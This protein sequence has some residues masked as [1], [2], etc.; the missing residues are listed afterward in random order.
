VVWFNVDDGFSTS[1]K[2][3]G[4][5][6]GERMAAI[7]LWTI[8]GSW[9]SKHMTNGQIGSFM[10]DEWGA[11]PVSVGALITS[12]LWETTDEGF[13]FHDWTSWQR[14]RQQIEADREKERVRKK[15]WR[16]NKAG[17]SSFPVPDLSHG[18]DGGTPASVPRVS[19]Y[20][21]QALPSPTKPTLLSTKDSSS[22]LRPDVERLCILLRDLVIANGSK[23]PIIGPGW[24]TAARLMLVADGRDPEA[25]E[26]LM[27]WCQADPFWKANVLSMPKFRKG[28]DQIR[29]QAERQR[30]DRQQHAGKESKAD[31]AR[32]V[33][34]QGQRLQAEID[35]K[36]IAS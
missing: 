25:A 33:I 3:L 7:G 32:G 17:Q 1:P 4:I 8:A 35:R 10:L 27:R 16:D 14:S 20:P 2:V 18:T 36:A 9:C 21:S 28:Y 13:V 15:T 19:Q 24:H 30:I 23:P 34:A 6:R 12:G 31:R 11:D 22:E 26:R 5:P 29:L